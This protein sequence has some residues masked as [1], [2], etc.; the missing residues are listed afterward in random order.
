MRG[1]D[2]LRINMS[3]ENFQDCVWLVWHGLSSTE[4]EV[5]CVAPAP[6]PAVMRPTGWPSPVVSRCV[7]LWDRGCALTLTK[8]GDKQSSG[9]VTAVRKEKR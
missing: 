6:A 3:G 5:K 8:C 4:P 9:L 1:C 7:S 2:C